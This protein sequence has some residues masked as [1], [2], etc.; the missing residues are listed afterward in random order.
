MTA[1]T[2]TAANPAIMECAAM[3]NE[4]GFQVHPHR[5]S[6]CDTSNGFWSEHYV[7]DQIVTIPG[8]G[9]RGVAKAR[10]AGYNIKDAP[11]ICMHSA[12]PNKKTKGTEHYNKSQHAKD[13]LANNPGATLGESIDACLE[14]TLRNHRKT[15]HQY[16]KKR[17]K[18]LKKK[19]QKKIQESVAGC[20]R[21]IFLE[22]LTKV[23]NDEQNPNPPLTSDQ[24]SAMAI[25]P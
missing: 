10:F 12:K 15:R 13:F 2:I 16:N 1:L 5:E 8:T 20:L 14:G 24:V 23:M 17:K 3:L 6:P 21:L 9:N 7:E 25:N 19:V 18:R 22:Y 4:M 11:C